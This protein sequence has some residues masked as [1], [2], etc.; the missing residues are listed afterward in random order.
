MELDSKSSTEPTGYFDS[1][2][3]L[4]PSKVRLYRLKLLVEQDEQCYLC[5]QPVHP[6]KAVLDHDHKTGK[7]RSVLHDACN[8]IL[9]KVENSI[10]RHKVPMDHLQVF[11]QGIHKYINKDYSLNPYHPSFRTEDEKKL[12]RNKKAKIRRQ[13]KK[14]PIV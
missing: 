5:C 11:A 1:I 13:S 10:S 6:S 7:I 2:Y 9:G 12:R 4:R 14:S 8:R 3:R